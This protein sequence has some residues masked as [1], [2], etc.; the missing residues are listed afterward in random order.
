M[1]RPGTFDASALEDA[2]E[3]ATFKGVRLI[4]RQDHTHK[5]LLNTG[6][7]PA[8]KFH[9]KNSL[10]SSTVLFTA[11]ERSKEGGEALPV[12]ISMKVSRQ[13]PRPSREE[14]FDGRL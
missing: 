13:S 6:V 1:V 12:S 3:E 2:A 11:F 14:A 10:K 7:L 9:E 8:M 5:L 4:M